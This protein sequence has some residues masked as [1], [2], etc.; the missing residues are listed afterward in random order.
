MPHSYFIDKRSGTSADTLVAAG[1]A[2]LLRMLANQVGQD[3]GSI[4]LVDCGACYRVDVPDAITDNDLGLIE[5]LPFVRHLDTSSQ[6][7]KLGAHYGHGFDYDGERARREVYRER[8]KALPPEARARDAILYGNPEL[9]ALLVEA[10]DSRLPLY[11]VI[12]QMKVAPSFN[13]PVVR[14]RELPPALLRAHIRLLL[15]LF[16]TQ[17]NPLDATIKAWMAMA[18]QHSLGDAEM[19]ML[20]VV[21]PTTGKGAARTKANALT[22]GGQSEFWLLELLKFAGFFALGHPQVISGSKDR[23]TYVLRPRTIRL[24]VLDQVITTFRALHWS[25]TPAKIDVLAALDLTRVLVEFDRRALQKEHGDRRRRG[26]RPAD[27]VHGFDV[28]FYKDMGS[29]F[30]VLNVAALNV[31]DWVP[32]VASVA[33]ADQVLAVLKEHIEVVGAI[34]ARDGEERTEEYEL[35]RRYRDFLSGRDIEPFLDFAALF[36]S[37]LSRKIERGEYTRR[38][39][40][41][42]LK[43]LIA[44]TRQDFVRV[45]ENEGFQHI[46]DAIRRST[47]TLQ[48]AKGRGEPL[49]FD[50]RYGL[51]QDLVRS[52]NDAEAFIAALSDFVAKY[53]N[54][55]AQEYE[56]SKGKKR[57]TRITEEDLSMLIRLLAEGYSPKTLA[58]LLV[59]FGSAKASDDV[60]DP[61]VKA[62]EGEPNTTSSNE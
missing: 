2:Q 49:K 34:R 16:S 31:P 54:E 17:P 29:A 47:V 62:S 41:T 52:A 15:D 8:R 40:V 5:A 55:S 36:A 48:Y 24:D 14:W 6:Q 19:T 35:L 13:E 45:I 21:N 42:T 58:R 22:I 59:A 28:T 38:F 32:S 4:S 53:N 18:K 44:M 57:R 30:A 20:Q 23:K 9:E 7:A 37:Y 10:P 43:E 61:A 25:S 11:L 3:G 1:F 46:A 12:N 39:S 26:L 51:A 33:E 27:R 56:T 60:G 50:I